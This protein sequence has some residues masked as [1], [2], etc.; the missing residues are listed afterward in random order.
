MEF[1]V[2]KT[3]L[4]AAVV[5]NLEGRFKWQNPCGI[6]CCDFTARVTN[7]S[8][9][10]DTPGA[11]EVNQGDLQCRA[12]CLADQGLVDARIF[13]TLIQL[14]CRGSKIPWLVLWLH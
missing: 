6:G 2:H 4:K 10:S 1:D 5:G 12:C 8:R 13:R 3:G 14:I 7:D 9:G 11:Q